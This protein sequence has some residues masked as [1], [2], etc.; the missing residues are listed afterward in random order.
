MDYTQY[1][2]EE[3]IDMYRDGEA[4]S[5]VVDYLLNKY[6]NLVLGR[7][8]TMFIIG[9]DRDDLI[10]EGMIGLFKAIKDFDSGRDASFYTFAKLC[11]VRQM[12]TAIE[13]AGRKKHAPLNT[14][15][16]IYAEDFQKEG[17]VN[18]E[19]NIIDKERA[20]SLEEAFD[21]ELSEFEKEVLDLKM[22]DMDY[23]DIAA[24]LGKSP[25]SVDNAIQRIKN[26]M[27]KVLGSM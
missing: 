13:A 20:L 18:P 17:G 27:R 26:K 24:V 2:D 22:M 15:M 5:S 23:Q 1:T 8:Q 11:V 7:T 19:D 21:S 14:Y 16:S 4:D 12:Y 25:K 6:K 10:Q 3:L 9:S